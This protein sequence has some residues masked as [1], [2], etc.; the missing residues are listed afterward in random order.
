MGA[1]V[2][3]SPLPPFI[4]AVIIGV[5]SVILYV[6][7]VSILLW[8]RNQFNAAFYHLFIVRFIT[9]FLNY[10]NSFF[11]ARF[12]R[13]G[14]FLTFFD[15]LPATLLACFF[16]FN[17]Y[18]FHAEILSTLFISINRL[19]LILFPLKH[20]KI[21][22]YI[23]PIT[24]LM[25]FLI[26][27]LFTFENMEYD[28]YVR[29]QQD[30]YMFTLDYYRHQGHIYVESSFYAAISSIL[31][32]ILCGAINIATIA[33]YNRSKIRA[34]SPLGVTRIEDARIESRLT[35]YAVITFLAQLCMGIYMIIIYIT[36]TRMDWLPSVSGVDDL[37]FA[38]I[39]QMPWINDL[40]TIVFPSW[41]LLWASSN[42]RDLL[43]KQFRTK[44][45]SRMFVIILR[46]ENTRT[47]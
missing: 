29:H 41:A 23:F 25:V 1:I 35:I 3:A 17:F 21:W 42:V 46:S 24:V 32:C 34:P 40:C 14:F 2:S 8:D 13:V 20:A 22:K 27:V 5:P 15:S 19:T 37:F 39:N 4:F 6:L 36:G 9:N 18:F 28:F 44:T 31:F 7:E 43:L 33:L 45:S 11:Y 38:T 10:I 12:G 16:F 26:P 30:N 47:Q